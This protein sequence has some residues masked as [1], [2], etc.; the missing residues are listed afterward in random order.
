MYLHSQSFVANCSTVMH[1]NEPECPGKIV[2]LS[3]SRSQWRLMTSEEQDHDLTDIYSMCAPREAWS[4]SRHKGSWSNRGRLNVCTQRSMITIQEMMTQCVHPRGAW[5]WSRLNVCTQRSMIRI[6]TEDHDLTGRLNVCTQRSMI[7]IQTEDHDL[8]GRLNVCTQR[9]MI[10]TQTEDHDLTGRLNVC[11]PEGHDHEPDKLNVCT[12][13]GHDHEPDK[14][15][16]CTP[17]G[18]DHEPARLLVCT[19]RSMIMSQTNSMCAPQR[20]MIMSQTNSMCAPQRGMIMSQPDSLC[21]PRGAWSW[22][23]WCWLDLCIQEGNTTIFSPCNPHN[24]PHL[25]SDNMHSKHLYFIS[26][27]LLPPKSCASLKKKCK[28]QMDSNTSAHYKSQ[29][30]Y[31]KR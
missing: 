16:V 27:T 24:W 29:Q 18:H 23:N 6:Q 31:T 25:C 9:S 1:H 12:P 8:T 7:R 5:L 13:E 28:F 22:S 14:L 21:A 15:N 19:Q 4:W 17:E 2:L 26:Y 3:R 11:T 30:R 10:R 20:G